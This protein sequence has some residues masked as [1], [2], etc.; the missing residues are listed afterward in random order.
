MFSWNANTSGNALVED[1]LVYRN[2]ALSE[3]GGIRLGTEPG[4]TPDWLLIQDTTTL[5][6]WR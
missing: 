5:L 2:T 1:C 3:G 4:I 6:W